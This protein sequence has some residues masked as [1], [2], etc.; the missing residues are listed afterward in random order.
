MRKRFFQS[1]ISKDFWKK[2]VIPLIPLVVVAVIVSTMAV[3]LI[4]NQQRRTY[5]SKAVV[6]YGN[7]CNTNFDCPSGQSCNGVST[8]IC[9]QAGYY[10]TCTI[11]PTRVPTLTPTPTRRPTLTPV[12]PPCYDAGHNTPVGSCCVVYGGQSENPGGVSSCNTN[13]NCVNS[14]TP[15]PRNTNPPNPTRRP[16]VTIFRTPAPA[17]KCFG[18]VVLGGCCA[19]RQKC[20]PV[21]DGASCQGD[22]CT[23]PS[24]TLT[25]II[26]QPP[27]PPPPGDT[28]GKNAAGACEGTCSGGKECKKNDTYNTCNCVNPPGCSQPTC[29]G[30]LQ[31]PACIPLG[32]SITVKISG[33][34]KAHGG[35]KFPTWS[36]PNGQDDIV[37]YNGTEESPHVWSANI[38][39]SAHTGGNIN[40][41]AYLYNQC[42]QPFFCAGKN[43]PRCT[44]PTPIKTKTPTPIKTK[45]PTPTPTPG[46]PT[47]TPI[48]TC[49]DSDDGKNY[50]TFGYVTFNAFR[51]DDMCSSAS[52]LLERY[53]STPSSWANSNYTCPQG[54]SYGRC[55]GPSPTPTKTPTPTS[56]FVTSPPVCRSTDLSVKAEAIPN[57][58]ARP[59]NNVDLKGTVSGTLSGPITYR[60]NCNADGVWD[61]I[62]NNANTN[63]L[64][65]KD[66]CNYSTSGY[67]TARVSVSRGSCSAIDSVTI[68]V[69]VATPTPTK[70]LTPTNTPKPTKTPTPPPGSTSIPGPTNTPRPTRTPTPGG[71]TPTK[72]PTP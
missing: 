46:G 66:L 34:D 61:K 24:T 64:T 63:S 4:Y 22:P 70:K 33:E 6:T 72:T 21:A 65:A 52:V 49:R 48:P 11:N 19:N 40:V 14:P 44:T 62:V 42:N 15:I 35:V 68:S 58:G 17:P 30:T 51:I 10:Q 1:Q 59:L 16:P 31:G 29:C 5:Q 57:S 56:P 2:G 13:V 60:F 26:T 12:P 20:V 67:K 55:L 25:P 45:T 8:I 54:C 71:P 37:W 53:C 47:S 69:G 7:C 27:P 41:N 50:Y 18:S 9:A 36:D 32:G 23:P 39:Q 28:C 3:S 43:I 38:P